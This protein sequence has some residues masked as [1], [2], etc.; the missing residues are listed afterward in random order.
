MI[1]TI[2]FEDFCMPS[3][4][5]SQ[6]YLEI[7]ISFWTLSTQFFCHNKQFKT[8]RKIIVKEM[9]LESNAYTSQLSHIDKWKIKIP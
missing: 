9:Q 5:P 1:K 4:L 8:N 3:L 2:W 7:I 6:N